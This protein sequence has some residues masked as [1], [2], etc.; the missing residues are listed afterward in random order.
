MKSSGYSGTPLVKKLGFKPGFKVRIVHPP[1][2]FTT[3]LEELPKDVEF[4]NNSKHPKD[5][6]LLFVQ[7]K[8]DLIKSIYSLRKELKQNG[9]L[10][11]SWPK[12]ASGIICDITEDDIRNIAIQNGLVDIKVCA[13]DDTWSGLKLVIPVKSR[14][15]E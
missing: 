3:L 9:M 4:E 6:I 13:I 15:K 5:L 12:K 10:W 7:K 14:I 1:E 11:V 8:D 2:Y